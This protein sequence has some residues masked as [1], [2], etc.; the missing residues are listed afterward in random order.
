MLL[1]GGRVVNSATNLVTIHN[2]ETGEG[3]VKKLEKKHN[4][5]TRM[6]LSN[7]TWIDFLRPVIFFPTFLLDLS[8]LITGRYH[9]ACGS[10]QLTGMQE[11]HVISTMNLNLVRLI[12]NTV[13]D[14]S[15]HWRLGWL[16]TPKQYRGEELHLHSP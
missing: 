12:Q 9:H 8:S 6:V 3:S 10:Y 13:A 7:T 14:D 4:L 15:G 5:K 1:T 16:S 11:V 2:L